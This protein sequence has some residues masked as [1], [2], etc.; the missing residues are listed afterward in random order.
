MESYEDKQKR[1]EKSS[2]LKKH[3][4]E[5]AEKLSVSTEWK[6]T[7]HRMKELMDEWK[8]AGY[9]GKDNNEQWKNF[10]N[11]G[12]VFLSVRTGILKS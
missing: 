11:T 4:I 3:I 8:K 12:R 6:A 2:E 10:R 1:F 9:S 5:E 7:S